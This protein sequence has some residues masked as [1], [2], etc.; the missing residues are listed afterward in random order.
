M[1]KHEKTQAEHPPEG[2]FSRVFV[3][4]SENLSKFARQLV[5]AAISRTYTVCWRSFPDE[6]LQSLYSPDFDFWEF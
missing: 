2:L 6:L 5:D 3:L 1:Q 4:P